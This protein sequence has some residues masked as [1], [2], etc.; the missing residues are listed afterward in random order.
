[1]RDSL[2]V[3]IAARRQET[4]DV[5]TL[6][7]ARPF[8]FTAGQYISVYFDGSSAPEGKAYSLSSRPQDALASISVKDIGGEF[9]SR[10]CGL[11][12]GDTMRISQAYGH[13][14]PQV[15]TPLVGIAAGVGL[16]P[17]WSILAERNAACDQLYYGNKTE[18]DIVYRDELAGLATDVHHHIS[19][20]PD[21]SYRRGRVDAAAIA[22]TAHNEAHYLLCG[23][24]TFVRDMFR[25][26]AGQ[27]IG[28]ER[29]ATEIF[30]E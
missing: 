12:P 11:Q 18:A 14:S 24:V 1:M 7:F 22:T 16:S 21:T 2:N 20:Q 23:S 8:A 3:T 4:P 6:Y 5:A 17:V 28:R 29:I 13:F 27:G 15:D 10:L 19:R 30:F 9:S 25:A 26:L